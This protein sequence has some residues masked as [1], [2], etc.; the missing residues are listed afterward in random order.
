MNSSK[1][2]VGILGG[3]QLGLMLGE[4]ALKLGLNPIVFC[5]SPEEPALSVVKE[6]IIAAQTDINA[7]SRFRSLVSV[8][9]IES[10][11]FPFPDLLGEHKKGE[12]KI[13]P[14]LTTIRL[15]SDKLCQKNLWL[16]NK[17]PTSPFLSL[18]NGSDPV[19]WLDKVAKRFP[20]G[21][22][23]KTAKNGYDGKGVLVCKESS[24]R[25]IEFCKSA[26]K[27]G[28]D[29]YAE[30]KINF[31]R[32]LAIIG[33]KSISGKFIS[34]PLI[35]SEQQDGICYLVTGPASSL[36]VPKS[37]E[38]KA[39]EIAQQIAKAGNIVG[40]FGVE[41]FE[42]Q[43]GE[44]LINEVAPRVHNS[45]HYTQDA[46]ETS[47]FENHWRAILDMPLGSVKTPAAFAMLN[48]L[49]P[50]G[51]TCQNSKENTPKP[52]G[53]LALHWYNKSEIKPKRKL[54]HINGVVD[55][56][57]QLPALLESLKACEKAWTEELR[58]QHGQK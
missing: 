54:G 42:D 12:A 49:G 7:I 10:E 36:G 53:N 5:S 35:V 28:G 23:I 39:C 45:G 57:S 16:E 22:V 27:R 37:L 6:S 14:E 52:S 21:F 1:I 43:N 32:E 30:E 13:F 3:G 41:F 44:L 56:I 34:Y 38:E 55:N 51:M 46:A 40:S 48:L 2:N 19:I 33:C 9:A 26:L 15:L 8:V 18:K 11:F 50:E 25:A 17:L 24:S 58:S 20:D 31:K 29:L 47:Q 4:A